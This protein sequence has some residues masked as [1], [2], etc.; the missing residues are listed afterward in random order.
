MKNN[1]II[2]K[3]LAAVIS[4]SLVCTGILGTSFLCNAREQGDNI[5]ITQLPGTVTEEKSY[6]NSFLSVTGYV[7]DGV[8]DRSQYYEDY[9]KYNEEQMAAFVAAG[10]KEEDYVYKD[11]AYYCVVSNEQEFCR[12]MYNEP[13]VIEITNDLNLGFKYLQRKK[14]NTFGIVNQISDYRKGNVPVTSPTLI[15]DGVSQF[16]IKNKDGFTLYS[17]NGSNIYN[18]EIG[19]QYSNDIVIRN[20]GIQGL[21]EWDDVPFTQRTVTPGGHKKFDWDNISVYN[22]SNVWIDHCTLGIAYDGTVDVTDSST[23]T[24]SWCELGVPNEYGKKLVHENIEHMEE[25]YQESKDLE[26]KKKNSYQFYTY[27]R[28]GGATPE[29]IERFAV[30][31][32]K[33]HAFSCSE[34]YYNVNIYDRITL[35]YNF[36]KNSCQRVPQIRCGNAHMFNCYVDSNDY[37]EICNEMSKARSFAAENGCSVL[38]L[39]RA[40]SCLGGGTIGTDTCVFEG[41]INPIIS[42]EYQN[43]GFQKGAPNH[44]LIVNSSTKAYGEKEAYIGSSWD[45]NGD[46]KFINSKSYWTDKKTIGNF[47]WAKWKEIN[48]TASY[49]YDKCYIGQDELDYAYKIVPLNEVKDTLE[50]YSGCG[51]IK[52]NGNWWLSTKVNE[53]DTVYDASKDLPIK[54]SPTPTPTVTQSPTPTVTPTEE[55]TPTA[56]VTEAPTLAPTLA[57]TIEPSKVPQPVITPTAVP[58]K[59]PEITQPPT[60]SPTNTP[61]VSDTPEP[62]PQIIYGDINGDGKVDLQDTSKLLKVALAIE[63]IDDKYAAA[64]DVDKNGKINLQDVVIVLNWAL[65]IK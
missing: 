33:V 31:N 38:G 34:A 11:T 5:A 19:V 8:N 65:G 32:D 48:S 24:I 45:N 55:P 41:V 49:N 39:C 42:S 44:N 47:K 15:Q 30:L 50:K 27:L 52:M 64:A 40:N 59:T 10:G 26:Y 51:K 14:V 3:T 22:S 61:V 17:R 9:I 37:I 2:T 53:D 28:D 29:Q 57:P 1:S 36:Y 18:C 54:Q 21:N 58:T 7:Q 20:I 23:V 63:K 4:A 6:D 62:T 13:K 35:A 16:N 43:D 25:L 60:L 56:K 46:N 12:A